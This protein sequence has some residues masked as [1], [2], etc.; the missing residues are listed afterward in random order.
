[1]DEHLE[2]GMHINAVGA[3]HKAVM[4]LDPNILARSRFFVDLAASARDQAGEML[5]AIDAGILPA[6]VDICE[7]GSVLS[8]AL[9]GRTTAEE[10]TVYKSLG[11]AAQDLAAMS[12]I[13][14]EAEKMGVG[15]EIR[16]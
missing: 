13:L 10:I 14:R 7:I 5:R 2:P 16:M 15:T 6:D 12:Y 11:I 3:S 4:E 8:G 9:P 1:M